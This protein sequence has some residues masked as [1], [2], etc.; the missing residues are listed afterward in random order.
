[1]AQYPVMPKATAVW[2]VDNTLLTFKQIA[3]FTGL[4]PLEIEA[5]ADGDVARN[6]VGKDPVAGAEL[7]AEEIA[8]CQ[9]DPNRPL[10]LLVKKDMPKAVKRS[11]GPRYTP[12]AKRGDKPDAIAWFLK[13]HGELSDA[14]IVRLIGTT[15]NTIEAIRTRTHMNIANI[16]ARHPVQLGLCSY[17]DIN[18][19]VEK[20]EAEKE[21]VRLRTERA[22]KKAER[23][24]TKK[25]KP[26]KKKAVK[27]AVKKS[28]K[29]TP[30]AK[31]AAKAKKSPVK[32]VT[33]KKTAV[34]KPVVKKAT[35]KV[36]VK[37]VAV[38]K[39]VVKKAATKKAPAKKTA[40]KKAAVK[41]PATKKTAAKK[42]GK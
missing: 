19:A 28:V 29:K 3:D 2:L 6:I 25:E 11:K 1:M 17:A 37:K 40:T 10:T 14:Q 16:T 41:K 34:K 7:T 21:R 38:K 4:H 18:A 24:K 31:V 13:N 12:V 8:A 39:E 36:A 42:A 33:A 35:K 23:E 26:A 9:A 15:K 32:K 30:K 27:K 5:I 22:K 20:I